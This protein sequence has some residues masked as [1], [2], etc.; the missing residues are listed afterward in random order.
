MLLAI[1]LDH[2]C[3][4]GN[5]VRVAILGNSG[6]GKSTLA[7]WLAARSGAFMLDLDTVAWEPGQIAVARSPAAAIADVRGFCEDH[8]HWVVEGCYATLVG[9]ALEF[10]PLLLFL[11]P[12]EWQCRANCRA[13][14]W[15]SHKYA[16]K[17]EQ[18]ERLSFLL[19]WVNEYYTREGELSLSG[20]RRCY[21][22]YAGPKVEVTSALELDS[23]SAEVLSWLTTGPGENMEPMEKRS[24][25]RNAFIAASPAQVYAAIRDPAR[26]SRWWGPAGFTNTIHEFDFRPG[27][28]WQLTM[29]GPDGKDYPNESR[30]TRLVSNEIFEIEHLSGHHFMLT[31]ELRASDGGTRVDWRQTFDTVEH[32]ERIAEFVAG[33][34]QQNL[35][36]LAA[37]VLRAKA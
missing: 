19:S 22:S 15:E 26:V 33:A 1:E 32:Y 17:A 18:D 9:A 6:S 23:P 7:R 10:S 13:R 25:A 11:N 31:L 20:H 35:E 12:G 34:N 36:R 29:H 8:D 4:F 30:F 28:K 27:G 16:S 37:E 3:E 5:H 14:P 2:E 21:D 24:D